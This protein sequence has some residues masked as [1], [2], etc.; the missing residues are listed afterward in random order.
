MIFVTVGTGKF[1]ELVEEIDRIALNTKEEIIVQIG[2]G[3]YLPKNIRH[4]R[5]KDSLTDYYKNADLIIAHGGAGTTYE[6]L[7]MGKR[8]VS[9]ANLNRTDVHQNEI[10]EALSKQGYLVWCRRFEDLERC[11]KKARRFRFKKYRQPE[12][13]IAEKIKEFLG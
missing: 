2:E 8:L 13:K 1:D 10:L 9:M 5:F 12:C 6:L 7:A 11:I 4:F 3:D